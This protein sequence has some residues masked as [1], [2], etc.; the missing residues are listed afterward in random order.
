M[1]LSRREYRASQEG[2]GR[3]ASNRERPT[4]CLAHDQPYFTKVKVERGVSRPMCP[5]CKQDE[6]WMKKAVDQLVEEGVYPVLVGVAL[7]RA[8]KLAGHELLR[9]RRG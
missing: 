5:T 2:R 4:Y 3:Y 1:R 6:A 8:E 7:A 9:F